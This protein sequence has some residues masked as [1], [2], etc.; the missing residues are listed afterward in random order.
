[1]NPQQ[2]QRIQEL[3]G[4]CV[5]LSADEQAARLERERR[6]G[7]DPGILDQVRAL[8]AADRGVDIVATHVG[9]AVEREV[10]SARLVPGQQVGHYCIERLL[11]CGGMGAVYLARRNDNVYRQDVVIKIVGVSIGRFLLERFQRERQILADLNHPYIARLL[12]GGTL[13]NGQPYLV[14]EYVQGTDIA[15]YCEQKR[16]DAR[17]RL[18]LF[19][20]ICQA[21]QFAHTNLI[22][23]RDIK[24]AN[25]LVDSTGTPKLLDFGIAKLLGQADLDAERAASSAPGHSDSPRHTLHGGALMSPEYAS[26]E[27]FRGEAVSTASDIYSLGALAYRLL[28]GRSPHYSSLGDTVDGVPTSPPPRPTA[29]APEAGL[30]RAMRRDVDAIVLRALDDRPGERYATASE[31]AED[32]ERCL[33]SRPV[34]ARTGG[35]FGA[36]T[37][38]GTRNR[39][40]SAALAG[41][42][43]L[44]VGFLASVSFLA[45]HLNDERERATLAA[46]KTEQVVDFLFDLFAGADPAS[47]PGETLTA[48]QLLDIGTSRIEQEL[49]GRPYLQAQLLHRV[50]VAY[51]NLG[52]LDEAL[53]LKNRALER[54]DPE[55]TDLRWAL[56]IERAD[57]KRHMGL[58]EE[59]SVELTA[60]VQELEG[61][62]ALARHLSS[63]YNNSGILAARLERA[64]LAED[65]ARR[66]LAVPLPETGNV[67]RLH[68]RYRH[69]LALALSSQKRYDEAIELLQQVIIDKKL[70]LGEIHPSVLVSTE[71]LAGA[72]RRSGQLERA[73]EILEQSAELNRRLYGD[74]STSIADIYN[75]LANV[76]HDAGRYQDAEVAYRAALETLD[77]FPDREPLVHAFVVNNLASLYEDYGD[78]ERAEPLFRRSLDMRVQ[79]NGKDSLSS[80]RAR[81]NLGRLLVKMGALDEAD[82]LLAEVIELLTIHFPD[83]AFRLASTQVQIGVLRAA[84][85]RVEAAIPRLEAALATLVELEPAGSVAVAHARLEAAGVLVR[86]GDHA[87]ARELLEQVHAAYAA[88]FPDPH[89]RTLATEVLLAET[90]LA[91]GR[92]EPGSRLLKAAIPALCDRL[93]PE[94][95]ILSHAESIAHGYRNALGPGPDSGIPDCRRTASRKPAP[96]DDERVGLVVPTP[97]DRLEPPERPGP[98]R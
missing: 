19:V 59:A 57:L 87:R 85:G 24:P 77:A 88:F 26:P 78:L 70:D 67:D 14:M 2:W 40:L 80:L 68:A 84:Q 36:V 83:N 28:T 6:D 16:L 17:A 43:L 55:D 49:E 25:V 22:V 89:P 33:Q 56:F 29:I 47:Y 74:S 27:Q 76:H 96:L 91:E 75:E 61:Q 4:R 46:V 62:P 9:S 94:A 95:W 37:K 58:T 44:I 32:I 79:L 93:S 92:L 48:R 39:G 50:A 13:E 66:A 8:L 12:D 31:L 52:I 21:V 98:T 45:L 90:M 69:N 86:A 34:R 72:Y 41:L 38:F 3:F 35:W 64:D 63:A 54:V 20:K 60:A 15:R 5:E 7:T 81:H 51:R 82:H 30:P 97:V 23:H 42:V 73:A 11:G 65:F 10:E 18:R 53:A 1:M 71:V